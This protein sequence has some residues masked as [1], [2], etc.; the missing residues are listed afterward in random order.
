MLYM[1][2][3]VSGHTGGHTGGV[4]ISGV[5]TKQA[6]EPDKV[7]WPQAA[8]KVCPSLTGQLIVF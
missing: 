1:P 7:Q 5:N 3:F 2:G 8:V 6:A 4:I